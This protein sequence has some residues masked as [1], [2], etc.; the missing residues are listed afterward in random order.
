VLEVH[1]W[2][3]NGCINLGSFASH[4]SPWLYLEYVFIAQN[5]STYVLWG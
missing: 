1:F 2:N 3:A 4:I 5:R